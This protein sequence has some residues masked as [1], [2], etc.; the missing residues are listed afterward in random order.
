MIQDSNHKLS[1]QQFGSLVARGNRMWFRLSTNP[2]EIST[3]TVLHNR[4]AVA[5]RSET[6][7]MAAQRTLTKCE[8]HPVA[9]P[10]G[11]SPL[12]RTLEPQRTFDTLADQAHTCQKES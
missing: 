4:F 3:V 11:D 7:P 2:A 8:R 10:R 9:Q 1:E 12:G 6:S 5:C